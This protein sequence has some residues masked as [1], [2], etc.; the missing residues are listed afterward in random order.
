MDKVFDYVGDD[1]AIQKT[2]PMLADQRS[3]SC[4]EFPH[5]R[6]ISRAQNFFEINVR[7]RTRINFRKNFLANFGTQ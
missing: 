5:D 1:P 3:G 4:P 6:L 7:I 2:E